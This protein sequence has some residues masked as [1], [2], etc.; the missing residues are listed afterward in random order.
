MNSQGPSILSC[1][2]YDIFLSFFFWGGILPQFLPLVLTEDPA[3]NFFC[4]FVTIVQ[5]LPV[6]L[7]QGPSPLPR[8]L[9]ME[10]PHWDYHNAQIYSYR[11][12]F[13]IEIVMDQSSD[14][15]QHSQNRPTGDRDIK[16]NFTNPSNR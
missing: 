4:Y 11:L 14:I 15:L 6:N 13:G 8:L 9:N 7:P 10:I 1:M 16:Q 3:P 2:D 5:I 12:E